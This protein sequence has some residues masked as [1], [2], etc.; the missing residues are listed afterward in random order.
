MV[1]HLNPVMEV[2]MRIIFFF[3]VLISSA[4]EE[5]KNLTGIEGGSITLSDPIT[6]KGFLSFGIKTIA[7]VKE[8]QVE[9]EE[10]SYTN[11]LHWDNKTGLFTIT[12]LQRNDSGIYTIDSKRGTVLSTYNKLTVY[13]SVPTPAVTKSN[14]SAESCILLCSVEKIEETT[15]L[16]YKDEEILNQNSSVFSLP[17]TVHQQD[18]NSFYRCVAANPAEKK[19]LPVS[20][21]T[22]CSQQNKSE[23]EDKN[24][25]Y[26]VVGIITFAV[27]VG[28]VV[29]FVIVT[30]NKTEKSAIQTQDSAN[31]QTEIE[32]TDIQILDQ[33]RH[34]AR[35]SSETGDHSNLI[36]VYDKLEAHR[37][38]PAHADTAENV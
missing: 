34:Q 8:R 29:L 25:N 5:E 11:R 24:R 32:Y 28:L 17:L 22:F 26:I 7:S 13:E 31:T 21:S 3:I 36:T 4:A 12:G 15:L 2:Q 38:F 1:V 19:T 20:V 9:I 10:E 37:I 27:I 14:L 35:N 23:S 16:W 30:K 18:F 6:E 33:R